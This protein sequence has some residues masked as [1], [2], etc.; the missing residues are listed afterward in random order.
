MGVPGGR[1]RRRVRAVVTTVAVC[2]KRVRAANGRT[3]GISPADEAALEVALTFADA[4]PEVVV[5][6]V[7]CGDSD[8]ITGLRQALAAGA[9]EAIHVEGNP[10][11][12]S[13]AVAEALA[14]VTADCN[15]VICGDHSLDRGTGSVPAFLASLLHRPQALGLIELDT[16]EPESWRATRRLDGGRRELLTIR[17]PAVVSVEAPA[18]HLRRASLP[19]SRA[20]AAAAIA[21]RP[22]PD[23]AAPEAGARTTR[24][25]PRARTLPAP[26]GD[27]ALERIRALTDIG[28]ITPSGEPV[29]AA[30]PEAAALIITT[31]CE[32]GYLPEEV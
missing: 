32:W 12:A 17:P 1:A 21:V 16:S 14:A 6:A 30:P 5:R 18:A 26:A 19:S 29:T 23:E 27:T 24:F 25:A 9:H 10:L 22:G 31:L 28:D 4:N 8:S 13:I 7:S 20:A 2:W 11:A 15:V 3:G